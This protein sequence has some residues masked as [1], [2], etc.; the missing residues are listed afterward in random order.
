[1]RLNLH[2]RGVDLIDVEVH[3]GSRGLYLDLTVFQPRAPEKETPVERKADLTGTTDLHT[4]VASGP[5][6]EQEHS[7]LLRTGFQAN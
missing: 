1:M 4:H 3:A 7:V 2:L 5:V 6:W